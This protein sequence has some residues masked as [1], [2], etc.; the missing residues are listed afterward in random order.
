[1]VCVC[2]V[3]GVCVRALYLPKPL[4]LLTLCVYLFHMIQRI[5]NVYCPEYF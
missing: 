1:V 3:C 5:Y 2:V 4:V